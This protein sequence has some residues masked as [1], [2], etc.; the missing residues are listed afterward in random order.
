MPPNTAC[1]RLVG[2]AAFSSTRVRRAGSA[3]RHSGCEERKLS[4][5]SGLAVIQ[6]HKERLMKEAKKFLTKVEMLLKRSSGWSGVKCDFSKKETKK[7]QLLYRM[8]FF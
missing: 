5:A 6:V 3:R 8:R 4:F 2:V 7:A 1:T